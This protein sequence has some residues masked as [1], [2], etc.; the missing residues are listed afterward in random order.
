M[1]QKVSIVQQAIV[2][3]QN[4]DTIVQ[5]WLNERYPTFSWAVWSVPCSADRSWWGPAEAPLPVGSEWPKRD[6]EEVQ[7]DVWNWPKHPF[8]AVA[9][10]VW[11]LFF[12]I[13]KDFRDFLRM[14]SRSCSLVVIWGVSQRL[15]WEGHKDVWR[16]LRRDNVKHDIIHDLY[17]VWPHWA[18]GKAREIALRGV[19]T[20]HS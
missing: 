20:L 6:K 15:S 8:P 9:P 4:D 10:A 19:K 3:S 5:V 11:P 1:G 17:H 2:F 18:E 16:L 14:K 7:L 12:L 13:R